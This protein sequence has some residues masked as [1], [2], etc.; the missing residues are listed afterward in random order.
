MTFEEMMVVVRKRR[1]TEQEWPNIHSLLELKT[2][3][4]NQSVQDDMGYYEYYSDLNSCTFE[5]FQVLVE[6]TKHIKT[7][8]K[9]NSKFKFVR[10]GVIDR[11]SFTILSTDEE[12]LDGLDFSY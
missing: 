1:E 10:G 12:L 6:L 7:G 3:N 9:T 2:D 4:E 11:H 5:E 8:R